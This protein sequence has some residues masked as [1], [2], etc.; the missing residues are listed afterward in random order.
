M[1]MKVVFDHDQAESDTIRTFFFR[2]ET[3]LI[4][5]AGQFTQLTIPHSHPDDRGINRWF[6]LSSSP[7]DDL[8]SITTRLSPKSSSFKKALFDLKPGTELNIAEPMGDFVLPKLIQTPLYFVAGG[9]GITPFHSILSWLHSTSEERPIKLL[10]GVRT[11]DDIIFQDLLTKSKIDYVIVV[12]EP[13]AAWGGERGKLEAE[14]ITGLI[15]PT[16]DSLVYISGPE[17]MVEA[18]QNQ[19][20][21]SSDIKKPQL[22]LDFFPNYEHI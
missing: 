22:V 18:L 21:R 7:T 10:Y 19:L 1:S 6:T 12:E 8:L 16:P 9:I 11:E 20:I 14:K 5:T 3:E 4:Y 17:P 13:S 15:E 2:H